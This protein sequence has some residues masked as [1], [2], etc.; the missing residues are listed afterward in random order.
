MSTRL[1]DFPV[2]ILIEGGKETMPH[3]EMIQYMLGL[4]SPEDGDV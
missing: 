1:P 4:D 2:I 3:D